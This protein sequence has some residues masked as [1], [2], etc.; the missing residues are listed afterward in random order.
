MTPRSFPVILGP[1]RAFN[2]I[3]SNIKT[4]VF[5]QFI[6]EYNELLKRRGVK[7]VVYETIQPRALTVK[8]V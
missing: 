7:N 5:Y 8:S 6:G 1:R 3:E 2:F 4:Y